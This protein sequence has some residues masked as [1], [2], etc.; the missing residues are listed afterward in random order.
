MKVD[1]LLYL[2]IGKFVGA[3]I[4]TW[5]HCA[6]CVSGMI[7]TNFLGG[8]QID[9]AFT[10]P[11]FMIMSGWFINLDKMRKTPMCDYV[12][13]KFKRLI[14]PS[15]M[16]YFV[17]L[18]LTLNMPDLSL[19]TYY[20][21]LNALFVCLCL[22]MICS[23]FTKNDL[24]CCF[25]STSFIL[26]IPYS[27]YSHINYMIPFL[28]AGYGLRKIFKLDFAPIIVII[29]AIIGICL[30][31][32]WNFTNSVYLSP[33]NSYC[34]NYKMVL[35]MVFRFII[36]FAISAVI[37]FVIFRMEHMR[38]NKIAPYGS[39][40]LVIYTASLAFLGFF[41]SVLNYLHFHTNRLVLID[42]VSLFLCLCIIIT[43]IR[44]ADFCK[45]RK[46]MRQLF[47]GE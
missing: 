13:A 39:Y 21:Y 9:I 28:W 37:V 45:K 35:I 42:F 25:V 24:I 26:F 18:L 29:C 43:T 10:M 23:K 44:F 11:L 40:S 30:C 19:F 32:F 3:F 31:P 22:I 7:W 8:R 5:S 12:K 4:V 27:D 2:D 16:W 46:R 20:W 1:R 6:Q 38:I 36:G 33:F 17:L 15:F 14:I 41:S 34:L 47:L